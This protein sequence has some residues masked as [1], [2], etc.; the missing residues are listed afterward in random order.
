MSEQFIFNK[1]TEDEV[2]EYAE[3]SNVFNLSEDDIMKEKVI[4]ASFS[5]E[6]FGSS[7][8]KLDIAIFNNNAWHVIDIDEKIKGYNEIPLGYVLNGK[9]FSRVLVLVRRMSTFIVD[10]KK[11]G[12][13]SY[14]FCKVPEKYKEVSKDKALFGLLAKNQVYLDGSEDDIK[15]QIQ[16]KIVERNDEICSRLFV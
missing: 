1:I 2:E 5:D 16:S 6:K 11:E 14:V 7:E 10:R 9:D 8:E 12:Y 4:L 15:S 13:H 3:S